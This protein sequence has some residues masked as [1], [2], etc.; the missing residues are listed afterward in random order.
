[1]DIAS[2]LGFLGAM[3]MVAYTMISGGGI[4]PFIDPASMTTVF[5]GTLFAVLY[6]HPIGAWGAGHGAMLKV[7]MPPIKKNEELIERMVE[8]AAIARKDGMMALEGQ[9]VPDK[10]FSKGMQMLV[11][12]ADETKL[13]DQMNQEIKAMKLRHAARQNVIKS[14]VDIAPA[15]GMVGTL[16]GLVF[17]LGNMAD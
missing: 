1:M 10:F 11:D 5:G 15:M 2:I 13:T 4:E 3:G 7:F 16:I 6:S 17:M 12:G 9:E 14:Y 8:L